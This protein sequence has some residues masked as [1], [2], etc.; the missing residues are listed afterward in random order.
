MVS[1][2]TV[3][4]GRCSHKTQ[5]IAELGQNGIVSLCIT[6]TCPSVR[7]YGEK[8]K[9]IHVKDLAKPTLR[10]PAYSVANGTVGPECAVPSAVVNA[11]LTEAGMISKN[12][13]NKYPLVTIKYEGEQK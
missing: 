8:L 7:K 9:E 3:D 12:L 10:N 11:S 6:S 1:V 2:Y 13:L 4:S 5:I